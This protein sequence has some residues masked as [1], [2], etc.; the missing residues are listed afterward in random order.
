MSMAPT[1]SHQVADH[2]ANHIDNHTTLLTN[3]VRTSARV[4]AVVAAIAM[5]V[6][7]ASIGSYAYHRWYHHVPSLM[8]THMTT[9]YNPKYHT[10]LLAL[11]RDMDHEARRLKCDYWITCGTLLGLARFG[12]IMPFDDDV[13]VCMLEHTLKR[14]A[15]LVNDDA[16]SPL[17]LWKLEPT[18][19]IW[20]VRYRDPVKHLAL[21]NV[22]IDVFLMRK[23]ASDAEFPTRTRVGAFGYARAAFPRDWWYEDNVFPLKRALLNDVEV[24][25]PQSPN[26][27][28]DVMYRGWR[29]VIYL[30]HV[31]ADPLCWMFFALFKSR[32]SIPITPQLTF[33]MRELVAKT[34]VYEP[35]SVFPPTA[36]TPTATG[37]NIE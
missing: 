22:D 13:D 9:L 8:D 33:D 10:F 35:A 27:C 18:G 20:R 23:E 5:L 3:V 1:S 29:E 26:P 16:S 31:H 2:I 32:E 7:L 15:R 21:N 25:A 11:M 19:S 28:L 4:V 12:G 37:V 24:W 36:H 30:T 14:F 6:I 17:L 34:R